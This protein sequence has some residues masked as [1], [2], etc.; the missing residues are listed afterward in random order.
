M[1]NVNAGILRRSVPGLRRSFKYVWIEGRPPRYFVQ[2]GIGLMGFVC[3]WSLLAVFGGKLAVSNPDGFHRTPFP[4][5]GSVVYFPPGVVWLVY[6]GLFVVMGWLFLLGLIMAFK[7]E[8]V[9]I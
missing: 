7:R 3:V 5:H 4:Y 8:A 2:L 9:R 1:S 6:H